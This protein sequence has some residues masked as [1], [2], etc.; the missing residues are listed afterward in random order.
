MRVEKLLRYGI[1]ESI[2]ESWR[3]NQGEELLPLQ[4]L[5]VSKYELLHGKSLIIS[6]PTSSGKTFCGEMAAVANLFR[7]K[8]VMFLVPLRAVAEEKYSD[9]SLKYSSLGIKI[10]ISTHDRQEDDRDIERG[11]FDLAIMINEK[12]NALLIKNLDILSLVHLIVVDE[13][14]MITDP[15]RGATLELA[16]TKIKSSKYSPQIL[17]LSAVLK[18]PDRLASWLGCQ[19][20]VEKS[21]PVE[22]LQGVLLNGEFHYRKH[23]SGEEGNQ[24][25][26][27]MES[28]ESHHILFANLK[29]LLDEKEQILVFLKSKK[30][31]EDCALLFSDQSHLPPSLDSIQA[32]QELENTTLKEKLILCLQNGV[33][34]H[35]AD[36]TFDERRIIEHF[37]STGEI[38]LIFSTTTLSL[39]INLPAKTVF[40]ETQKYGVGE[41]SGK[42]VMSPI[43]WSEYEN[44][45][46]RA[47]RFGLENDFGRSIIIAQNRF[48]FDTL[49]EGYIEGEEEKITSQLPLENPGDVVLDLVTSGAG[50]TLSQLNHTLASSLDR[51]LFPENENRVKEIVEELLEKNILTKNGE[52]LSPTRLGSLCAFKGITIKTGLAFKSKLEEASDL[53]PFSWI[54]SILN[55]KE[56]EEIYLNVNY[57]EEQNRVYEKALSE[58]YEDAPPA[59]QEIIKLLKSNVGFNPRDTRRVKLC[60]LL[61][62]WITTRS[63]IELENQYLC[64]SGQIEQIGKRAGWLLD[65]AGGIAKVIHQDRKIAF[66][67]KRLSLRLNFGVDDSGV[68]FARLRVPGL[69]RDFIWS[70]VHRGYFSFRQIKEAKLEELG[71]VIPKQVAQKLKEKVAEKSKPSRRQKRSDPKNIHLWQKVKDPSEDELQ[72]IIDGTPVKDKFLILVNGR[73]I[74]LPAKSFKYLVKLVWAAF[75]N[76]GGWIHKND[77]EPGEN[78][79]RYLHRLKKQILPSLIPGQSFME[80]NRLGGYRLSFPKDKISINSTLLLKNPDMEI[81]KMAEELA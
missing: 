65:A 19:L 21:R 50:K 22:L 13:L 54:Y 17:G 14:Q 62:E 66:F 79:T 51:G 64:R 80:N 81:K 25:L 49:W 67:L 31:C 36:L 78:Q 59:N 57:F 43:S 26:V 1:P 3:K 8:K 76:D 56:G 2:I 27:Q 39:G 33:A 73:K 52:I 4:S 11:D 24:N 34:F 5:A 77:F 29:K 16:L 10:S 74:N 58:K 44:M 40:I 63:T 37:Y 7:R 35:N 69:G 41:Y 72:L 61:T 45:S 75:Q 68:K 20:L 23:N 53:D 12:F 6:A 42:A 9:F 46:G 48:Q 71:K 60:F 30:N 55:T 18:D 47:G 38:R 70:L 28:E 15:S 32:L